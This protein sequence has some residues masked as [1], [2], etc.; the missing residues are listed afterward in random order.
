MTKTRTITEATASELDSVLAGLSWATEWPKPLADFLTK[1]PAVLL[2]AKPSAR[3]I[4]HQVI[5]IFAANLGIGFN[6]EQLT[7]IGEKL[8]RT[9]GDVIQWANKI[10]RQGIKLDKTPVKSPG[11]GFSKLTFS[12]KYLHS[13]IDT[14]TATGI[15]SSKK[16]VRNL[17]L[18][19]ADGKFEKG[20]KDPRLPLTDSNL[21]MQP[22][23]INRSY[24]DRYIFDDNGLP[25]APNPA[26]FAEDPTLFY[27]DEAD[28]RALFETLKKRYE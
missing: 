17:F 1:Y 27:D 23:E 21:V 20:H 9:T 8:G 2:P 22:Q 12:D 3:S 25:K 16:R 6:R 19:M 10:E 15:Q 5:A 28:L 24:R 7:R 26:K 14:T 11:Y 13:S 4:S 18:G